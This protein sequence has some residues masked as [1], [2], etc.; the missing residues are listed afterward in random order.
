MGADIAH[1]GNEALEVGGVLLEGDT[2][3]G[4]LVVVTELG[5]SA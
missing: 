4:F 5:E 1:I 3:G 2:R